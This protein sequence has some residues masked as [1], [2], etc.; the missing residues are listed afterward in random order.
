MES[1]ATPRRARVNQLF[2]EPKRQQA[3]HG[4]VP[5]KTDDNQAHAKPFAL[6]PA[7]HSSRRQE[8][9]AAVQPVRGPQRLRDVQ[10]PGGAGQYV[11]PSVADFAG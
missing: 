10:S 11:A 7:A 9:R 8:F 3:G 2:C 6:V 5:V 1:Q 4:A